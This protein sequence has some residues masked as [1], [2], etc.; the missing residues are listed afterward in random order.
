MELS[1]SP[2]SRKD[3]P[4][5]LDIQ[6]SFPEER[7]L[8]FPLSICFLIPIPKTGRTDKGTGKEKIIPIAFHF[9]ILPEIFVSYMYHISTFYPM[10]FPYS[11]AF[12]DD[13]RTCNPGTA[14]YNLIQRGQTENPKD[15]R[16]YSKVYHTGQQKT[17]NSTSF[18]PQFIVFP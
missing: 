13:G 15:D 7:I 11:T 16:R 9:L 10:T 18:T 5:S 2:L 3:S 14:S 6:S 4:D 8:Q 17:P 12:H 1:A